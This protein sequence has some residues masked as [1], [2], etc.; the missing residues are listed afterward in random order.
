MSAGIYG[1][2][3]IPRSVGTC[4]PVERH[5]Q[6]L[7]AEVGAVMGGL[8]TSDPGPNLGILRWFAREDGVEPRWKNKL[9]LK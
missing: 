9:P 6:P 5:S 1:G 8:T 4:G 7:W 3:T 2:G